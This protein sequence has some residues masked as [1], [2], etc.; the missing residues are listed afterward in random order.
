MDN[1]F[2]EI[3]KALLRQCTCGGM[4]KRR[5]CDTNCFIFIGCNTPSGKA[6]FHRTREA[7]KVYDAGKHER[8][9]AWAAAEDNKDVHS[10]KFME[11]AAQDFVRDAFVLD[12]LEINQEARSRL[13][14][15]DDPWLRKTV[16]LK[17]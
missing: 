9:M 15:P 2:D 16:E 5:E 3:G 8:D 14:H 6:R 13:I 7:L 4:L 17:E 10:A 1:E 11:Q 12:T